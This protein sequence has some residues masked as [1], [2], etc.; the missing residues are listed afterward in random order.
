MSFTLPCGHPGSFQHSLEL[1]LDARSSAVRIAVRGVRLSPSEA[2]CLETAPALPVPM[3]IPMP[4]APNEQFESETQRQEQRNPDATV[5]FK[6]H[7][8]EKPF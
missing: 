1:Y 4:D 6:I 3:P 5:S 2:T 7:G 8:F